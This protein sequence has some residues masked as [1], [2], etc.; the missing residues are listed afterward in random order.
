MTPRMKSLAKTIAPLAIVIALY[1][2][3]SV[4]IVVQSTAN[5]YLTHIGLLLVYT[6]LVLLVERKGKAIR[7]LTLF[8]LTLALVSM[9]YVRLESVRLEKY[10]G[11]ATDLD[12]VVGIVAIVAVLGVTWLIWGAILPLISLGFALYFFFG[13]L[14]PG[15]FFHSQ[16]PPEFVISYLGMG[17]NAGMFGYLVPIS[18]NFIF[19]FLVLAGL[20]SATRILDLFFEIGKALGNVARAGPAF[21]AV[22][23]STL[24]GM[25][26]GAATANVVF[27][28]SFTIPAMKER[29]FKPEYAAAIEATSSIGGQI[30]PPIMGAAAFVMA[31]FIG[32]PYFDIMLRGFIPAIVYYLLVAF[33][34]YLLCRRYNIYPPQR[35][36][37]LPSHSTSASRFC[38][39]PCSSYT[40]TCYAV[41]GNV[42]L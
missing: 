24:F 2:L 8:L 30:M 34:V 7:L 25:V 38:S 13:H 23:A 33:S 42:F 22:I 32:V 11:F 28:G 29:G 20:F 15:A 40:F 4:F 36:G 21:V 6:L 31:S 18:A 10:F 12:F 5:H 35:N 26:S 19:L 3:L 41:L 39:S 16:L 14:L 17:I 9:I 27:T 37:E 1:H